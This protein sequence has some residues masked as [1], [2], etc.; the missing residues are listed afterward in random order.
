MEKKF[1]V[2]LG[3]FVGIVLLAVLIV[4]TLPKPKLTLSKR[5]A[6]EQ[7]LQEQNADLPRKIGTI[8]WLNAIQLE[9]DAMVYKMSV[10]GDAAIDS[11][12]ENH[13]E[14]MRTILLYSI[15]M[16]NGQRDYG[17]IFSQGL[18]ALGL[19]LKA[20]IT[21]PSNRTFEWTI[22]P[23][24]LTAF[25]DSC[26]KNSTQSMYAIIDMQVQLTKQQLPAVID[27]LGNLQ[28]ISINAITSAS[29]SQCDI[30]ADIRHTD[31][32]I[33]IDYITSEQEGL[34]SNIEWNDDEEVIRIFTSEMAKDD[35]FRELLNS[36]AISHSN[37]ILNY[38]G[39]ISNQR[40]SIKIP[41]RII[42]EYC[43]VPK[44]LLTID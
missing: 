25:V 41:Y 42:R 26:Q 30:L 31:E 8:G 14:E 29:Y 3:C 33:E 32:D 34:L 6:I 24:E 10:V 44:T 39:R 36:L 20:T 23:S 12:Y 18:D 17:T 5:L 1:K 13:D 43:D 28:T 2:I 37:L 9:H 15:V 7:C 19:N 4:P 38:V 40:M 11:I 21:T 22:V 35:D 16:M 27:S